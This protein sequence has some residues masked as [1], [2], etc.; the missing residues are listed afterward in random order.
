MK[1]LS[2][3]KTKIINEARELPEN[4]DIFHI[5]FYNGSLHYGPKE[6][7]CEEI[8]Y[9]EA[10]PQYSLEKINEILK[11]CADILDYA[12]PLGDAPRNDNDAEYSKIYNAMKN[13]FPMFGSKTYQAV[14]VHGQ[15]LAR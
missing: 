8:S 13:E 5:F 4:D 11:Y 3:T 12:Y 9:S 1:D 15:Y 2:E 14:S 7:R 10:F 6:R